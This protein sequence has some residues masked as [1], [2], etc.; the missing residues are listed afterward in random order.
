MNRKFLVLVLLFVIVALPSCKTKHA[1]VKGSMKEYDIDFLFNK[2]KEN[3]LQYQTLSLKAEISAKVNRKKSN[4]NATLR[5]QRDSM[6]WISVSPGLGLEAAR[7][8]ITQ[9][10]L[11]FMNRINKEYFTSDFSYITNRFKV[12]ID[13]NML[14]SLLLG[15][16]FNYYENNTF[17]TAYDAGSY[18]LNA[19]ERAKQKKYI[20]N[21]DD[22]QRVL[23]QSVWLDPDNFKIN[24]IRIR[25]LFDE[26]R[27]LEATYTNFAKADEQLLASNVFFDIMAKGNVA[28]KKEE[29]IDNQRF[30]IELSFSKIEVDETLSTPFNIPSKYQRINL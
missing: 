3:E 18:R 2:M 10:S 15:S 12:D 8:L 28:S 5:I 22:A 21:N 9:D 27:K 16:D 13:Y 23:V 14:Q 20:R 24:Q 19:A 29:K 11:Y 4:L 1:V 6:I 25:S 30:F 17:R 26:S 7:I